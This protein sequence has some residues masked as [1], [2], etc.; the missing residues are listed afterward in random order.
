M[1]PLPPLFCQLWR[2]LLSL[3]GLLLALLCSAQ[4]GLARP[5]IL[6]PPPSSTIYARESTS[7]MVIRQQA[8]EGIKQTRVRK[9]D[10]L[11][12]PLR[13]KPLDGYYY[14]HFS[15][16]LTPGKNTFELLPIGEEITLT[17][18][19][20]RS[21]LNANFKSPGVFLFHGQQLLPEVCGQCHQ[22]KEKLGSKEGDNL[23]ISC[24]KS[25]LANNWQHSPAATLQC[26]SC[27]K[28]DDSSLQVAIPAGKVESSCF[29]CHI[30]KKA[31]LGMA[32]IHGPVGTGDCTVC[33]N[34]HADQNSSQLWADGKAKLCVSCHTDK[35]ELLDEKKSVYYTHG[36]LE[37]GGCIACHSPHATE[38]RFQLYKPINELCVGCHTS[39]KGVV[40]GHPVGGHPVQ[41]VKD[42]RR[43]ERVFACTSCHNPHGSD[44][45]FLLIGDVL[46]G[47]VC[48]QCH[49]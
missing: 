3:V 2:W 1:Y 8:H 27:H 30:S 9:G 22:G 25:I 34:P 19:P 47:Q 29:K 48:S 37:G 13:I 10:L 36:I 46:G 43:P 7:H 17:Y 21:L 39:F 16:P 28:K 4:P 42:P 15:L 33:H 24:H 20:L 49:Y 18:R 38:H 31:W 5:E 41:G 45:K 26:L 14:L 35:I 32:H 11:F 44:Y 12:S 40:K 23:C 6:S